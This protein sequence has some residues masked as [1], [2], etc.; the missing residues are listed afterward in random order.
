[1]SCTKYLGGRPSLSWENK[2]Y[3]SHFWY[4]PVNASKISLP[5]LLIHR[6]STNQN[7]P[8]CR[9]VTGLLTNGRRPI[10]VVVVV[11]GRTIYLRGPL[12]P[13]KCLL[14]GQNIRKI[15]HY[16][17]PEIYWQPCMCFTN[18]I[19][20]IGQASHYHH[21]VYYAFSDR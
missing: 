19:R 10:G 13:W 9:H 8:A 15:G 18:I 16:C 1:M 20:Y 4:K 14:S 5:L 7:L 17:L 11:Q 3:S 21:C 2:L 6:L 12:I